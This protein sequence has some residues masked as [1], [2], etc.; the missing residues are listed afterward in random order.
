MKM[1]YDDL[2]SKPAF[3]PF[4]DSVLPS[5][6]ALRRAHDAAAET[7]AYLVTQSESVEE[8]KR[9]LEA[10]QASFRDQEALSHSLQNRIQSLRHDMDNRMDMGPEE[11]ATERRNGL[12]QKKRHY[13]QKTSR[14]L[15]TLKKFIDDHLAAMLAAE[16]LGGPVVGEMMDIDREDLAAGFNAQGRPKKPK[17]SQDQDQRQ[18]RIDEIW[19]ETRATRQN[20]A[21]SSRTSRDGGDEATAAGVEMREL[22]EELL[23]RLVESEGDSEAAYVRLP[24]ESAAARFLVRS[25]VAQFHPK[26]S[27]RLRLIDFGKE[28]DD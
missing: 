15:K 13:D 7:T 2:T 20:E 8:A 16:E 14:L 3:L 26:D 9:R 18:R 5:L 28:L 4:P 22:T 10:E 21:H 25:K 1:A 19:G 12:K 23:N 24:R 11:A 6:L 27:A 17:E